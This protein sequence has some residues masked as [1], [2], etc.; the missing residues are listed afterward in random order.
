MR[1]YHVAPTSARAAIRETGLL[2]AKPNPRWE[3]YGVGDQPEGVYVWTSE[4]R[5]LRW[6]DDFARML[7]GSMQGM[8]DVWA[9]SLD[10]LEVQPDPV[11]PVLAE[12]GARYI[13]GDVPT[14]RLSL[15]Y[16][17]IGK[18]WAQLASADAEGVT[19]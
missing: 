7:A 14:D 13:T 5:A 6:A 4:Q 19:V 11:D 2:A 12:Q 10:G 3:K 17:G 18:E 1:G 16:T 8:N 9:V 15:L